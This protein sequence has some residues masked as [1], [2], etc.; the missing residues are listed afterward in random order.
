MGVGVG[1]QTFLLESISDSTAASSL[2]AGHRCQRRKFVM[3]LEFTKDFLFPKFP[4]YSGNSKYVLKHTG[5][6]PIS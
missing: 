5:K 6:G 1:K 3:L 4:K 2:L